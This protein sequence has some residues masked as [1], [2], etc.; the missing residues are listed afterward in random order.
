MSQGDDATLPDSRATPASTS[1][2]RIIVVS[3]AIP[4]VALLTLETLGIIPSTFHLSGGNGLTFTLWVI[5]LTPTITL[6]VFTL[7][8]VTQS[9]HVTGVT[10]IGK[11]AAETAQN[12]QHAVAWHLRQMLP[13]ANDRP[14]TDHVPKT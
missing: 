11:R 12:H 9:L 4:M 7:A 10:L 2:A 5:D 6:L 14:E 13:R 1:P 8:F 3:H